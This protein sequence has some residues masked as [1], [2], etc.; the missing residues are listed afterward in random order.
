[1]KPISISFLFHKRGRGLYSSHTFIKNQIYRI[2][3]YSRIRWWLY[4]ATALFLLSNFLPL[5]TFASPAPPVWEEDSLK[6]QLP[7]DSNFLIDSNEVMTADT[8]SMNDTVDV[9]NQNEITEPITY[10][11]DD[12]IIYDMITKK[13]FLYNKADVK[14][15]KIKLKAN[16]VDF[17]W[18]TYTLTSQGTPDS[19]GKMEGTPVFSESDKEYEAK[20][21]AY[22]FKTKRG[23]VYE[24]ITKE[25]DAYV[26][27]SEVKKNE[28]DEWYGRKSKYTTCDLEHPHF[29]FQARKVKIV[30]NK[31]MVTG[32]TNLWIADIPTPLYLPFGIFP[33]KQGRRSGLVIPEYGQ[34]GILGFFLRNGGY[35]WSVN[36]YLSLKFT[37]MVATNGTFGL[38]AASQYALR[39]KFNGA[40]SFNYTRTRPQ[41]P[42]LPGSKASNAYSFSWTHT[43]DPRSMPNSTFGASV[44]MQ[45]ADYYD[46]NRITDASRLNTA[47][48]S[49]ISYTRTFAGTPFSLSVNA[50][51]EQNLLAR[52]IG[53]TLPTFRLSM[54]RVTP[55]KSKIQTD[56]AKWYENI[57]L[58]YSFE[59]Q[60]RLDT[61]DSTL[62]RRE[63]LDKFRIGI[64][65]NISI[66]APVTLFKYI[67]I[68][69]SF[70]YQER[71]YFKGV[72]KTWNPDTVYITRPDG[73][74]DTLFGRIDTD[75]SWR[76]NS[77]RNFNASVSMATKVV[78]IFHF[79]NSKI[80]GLRHIFTPTLTFN[81]RPDFG[82][83]VWGY[84]RSVQSNAEGAT[85]RYSVFEPTPL[86][87][88]P[89]AGQEGSVN[90]TLLNTL[91]MKVFSKKDTVNHEKKVGLLDQ[92]TLS[93]GYNFAADSLRLLPFVLNVVSSRIFNLINL[94]LNA[95]FSPYATDSLNRP[96][97]TFQ[98]NVNKQLLRF[99]SANIS[100]STSLHSKAR[101]N[102]AAAGA[103]PRFM[104]DYVSYSP[105]QIYDFSIPWNV[106]LS[107]R[108]NLTR[109]NFMNPDTLITVQAINVSGDF[110]L[111]PHW[112]F[113]VSTGFDISRKQ[114]TLTNISVVRDLHCWE[115]IFNWTPPLPTFPN[116]QFSIILHP[117]S[118]TLKDLKLQ[119]RNSL[120]NF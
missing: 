45:S 27:S 16:L 52:T 8:L 67:N 38:G 47:F 118:P 60:N 102:A 25:G 116:Q 9:A 30:P 78:G 23:K 83:D 86:Y 57:G 26:H 69:P 72:S 92:A 80:K 28:Y 99:S 15:G 114:L 73:K 10:H 4:L 94:N 31:V 56:K 98:W 48:N 109:G 13:M 2:K 104:G 43:Q 18:T 65:Q 96:I 88:I 58:N 101:E 90:W 91:E 14:Y 55:F 103:P 107:Y 53:F 115:L 79:K 66:D 106:N 95:N 6:K 22:N 119:R 61:Y 41:D 54:S 11:A 89:G 108:F 75:T 32:P 63:T 39:Y 71:T 68:N 76:F 85:Q 40:V 112:K 5:F 17:D 62:M 70:T 34:D 64:N 12:S 77:A 29:Y 42:D 110:N 117:K 37:G 24:V 3:P 19:T 82:S 120:Q 46:A 49:T 87:G 36:D 113:T 97:N 105:N 51:H 93:G 1:M 59:A 111:T 7:I 81:Y 74:I 100:L 35:Y 50:R 44:N 84:Y 33:V 20:K 21:M